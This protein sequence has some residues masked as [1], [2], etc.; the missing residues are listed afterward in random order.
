MSS[1]VYG[2][3]TMPKRSIREAL[4]SAQWSLLVEAQQGG[5]EAEL[6]VPTEDEDHLLAGDVAVV[7]PGDGAAPAEA[8]AEFGF[9]GVAPLLAHRTPFSEVLAEP[10]SVR[11]RTRH[12]VILSV[13][14]GASQVPT[15]GV[16]RD[17]GWITIRAAGAGPPSGM[18][19]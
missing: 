12:W 11:R 13:A 14:I 9:V 10:V 16:R 6:R 7:D 5:L 18:K 2:S 1:S 19:G 15:P 17:P 8:D 4:G 3:I